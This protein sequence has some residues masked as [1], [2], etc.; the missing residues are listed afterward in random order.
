MQEY[1]NGAIQ[2]VKKFFSEATADMALSIV[3]ALALLL[4]GMTQHLSRGRSRRT[5]C[6][7]AADPNLVRLRV[8]IPHAANSPPYAFRQFS[9]RTEVLPLTPMSAGARRISPQGG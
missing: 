9:E 3:G 8:S 1:V 6:R 2:G 4:A 5:R 7:L